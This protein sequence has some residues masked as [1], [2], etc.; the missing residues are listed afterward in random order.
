LRG[1]STCKGPDFTSL[2]L[3]AT[4]RCKDPKLLA[5]TTKSYPRL[6]DLNTELFGSTKQKLDLPP[7]VDCDSHR[8]VKVNYSITRPNARVRKA[9]IEEFLVSSKHGVAHI[10][11]ML[12]FVC[13]SFHW[14]IARLLANYAKRSWAMQ[15][16]TM[17][18]CNAKVKIGKHGTPSPMYKELKKEYLFTNNVEYKFWF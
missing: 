13:S 8:A 4:A 16:N 3:K 12:D 9:C 10:T 1:G 6:E 15:A 11:S 7:S 17:I 2:K 18:L 14:H 5:N